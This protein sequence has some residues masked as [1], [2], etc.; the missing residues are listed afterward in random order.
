M[1]HAW[2]AL[3]L[4]CHAGVACAVGPG[5]ICFGNEPSWSLRFRDAS[6]AT[7]A[8]PDRQPL[9]HAGAT[10]GLPPLREWAWRGRP[11]GGGGEAVAFV[12]EASCS[13]GMSETKHPASVRL[14]LPDGR[15]LAGCCRI[16]ASAAR[17]IEGRRWR[18]AGVQGIA[19]DLGAAEAPVTVRF[20]D[21]R[22]EG[23]GGCNHFTGGFSLDGDRLTVGPLAA[24]MM[25]CAPTVMALETAVTRALGGT[26]RVDSR[27]GALTLAAADGR[28]L[29][30]VEARESGL[31]GGKWKV[32]GFNNGRQAVVS[33]L[34]TTSPWLRFTQ[35]SVQG[36]T[37][38][39]TF[40]ATYAVDGNR[41]TIGALTVTRKACGS[42]GVMQ[43]ERE[44]LAAL[45][46]ATT[47]TIDA[48]G[49]LDMH[50]A[51]G[52]RAIIAGVFQ[53]P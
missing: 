21:G 39:N 29:A 12:A 2:M 15:F 52:E 49:M 46:S 16:D 35:G 44:I 37:G 41:M 11:V 48:R 38:C 22:V 28:A 36:H 32:T 13:D 42:A 31:V 1:K 50:R 27:S 7:L 6:H 17:G 5:W 14:S 26:F 53:R 43:Q 45:R 51:D 19:A 33:P 10:R 47:W 24:T 23:F 9:D 34:E 18:L 8:F 40:R 20:S 3:A 4:A 25:S 30:F